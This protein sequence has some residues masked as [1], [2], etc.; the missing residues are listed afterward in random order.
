MGLGAAILAVA[1]LGPVWRSVERPAGSSDTRDLTIMTANV[2]GTANPT[3]DRAAAR[4]PGLSLTI[5]ADFTLQTER[6]AVDA[7]AWSSESEAAALSDADIGL[8]PLPDTPWTRGKC[9]FKLIQY[10]AA[11]L[12]VVSDPIGANAAIIEQGVTGLLPATPDAWV[13][14]LIQLA[15]DA[16]LRASLG[17]AGRARC[18]EHYSLDAVFPAM[19]RQLN[20]LAGV[21]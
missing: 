2:L 8:A 1:T 13:D 7:V 14:A 9:G 17:A 16:P 6:L 11:G 5:V 21:Q 3:L 20:T 15:Q 19:L 12:P 10:M 18:L 4:V